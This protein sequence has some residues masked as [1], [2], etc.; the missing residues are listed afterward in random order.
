MKLSVVH[1]HNVLVI[2]IEAAAAHAVERGVLRVA[3]QIEFPF[4]A[5][6]EGKIVRK[7]KVPFFLV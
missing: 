4:C 7:G 1:K 3:R 6:K 2:H 5:V